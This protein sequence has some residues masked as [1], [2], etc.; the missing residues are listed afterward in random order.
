MI[1]GENKEWQIE[2]LT[3]NKNSVFTICS[4][5]AELTWEWNRETMT[6][7]LIALF[8]RTDSLAIKLN[9]YYLIN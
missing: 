3:S 9:Y 1:H 6:K 7:F 5:K 2:L 8:S 4:H